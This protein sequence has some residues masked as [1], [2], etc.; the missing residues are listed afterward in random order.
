MWI[1]QLHVKLAIKMVAH[2]VPQQETRWSNTALRLINTIKNAS[3]NKELMTF[4]KK[5]VSHALVAAY[6][7]INPPA[8]NVTLRGLRYRLNVFVKLDTLIP[9]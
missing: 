7:A 1:A 4:N 9:L 8:M 6:N 2:H 3:V 5:T